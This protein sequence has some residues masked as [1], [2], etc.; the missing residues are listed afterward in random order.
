MFCPEW[1]GAAAGMSRVP[2]FAAA[3]AGDRHNRGTGR[4]TRGRPC[5]RCTYCRCESRCPMKAPRTPRSSPRRVRPKTAPANVILRGIRPRAAARTTSLSPTGLSRSVQ[6]EH[7]GRTSSASCRRARRRAPCLSGSAGGRRILESVAGQDRPVAGWTAP[8]GR[9]ADSAA[10]R[11]GVGRAGQRARTR[12]GPRADG[13]YHCRGRTSGAR[14][15][16]ALRISD[17]GPYPVGFVTAVGTGLTVWVTKPREA[18]PR[19]Y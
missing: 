7:T 19:W 3:R 4:P 1:V 18:C 14:H 13:G 11:G 16:A 8:A 12:P 5:C 10:G 17:E 9:F 6:A 2:R 15:A